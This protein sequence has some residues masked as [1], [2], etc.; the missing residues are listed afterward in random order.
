MMMESPMQILP[1]RDHNF[2]NA[3]GLL[4]PK[5]K[6]KGIG[7]GNWSREENKLFEDALAH[8][9]K[10]T[11]DRWEKVAATIPGKTVG[12][13]MTHYRD[14]EADVRQIEEAGLMPFS[15]G[16]SGS[17]SLI[18]DWENNHGFRG[19]KQP[20]CVG[21]KRS[22]EK[23]SEHERTKGVPWTEQEHKLFLMGLDKYGKGD[24]RSISRH[25]VKTRTPTQVASHAQKY[26][27]RLNSGGKDKRRSSIH[28]ITSANLLDSKSSSPS[29]SSI[30][31]TQSNSVAAPATS[32]HVALAVEAKQHGRIAN[33]FNSSAIGSKF[34]QPPVGVTPYEIE[35]R[36]QNTFHGHIRGYE[37]QP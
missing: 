36:A 10:D 8:F 21:A 5:G 30:L 17:S 27:I 11:D 33:G 3:S 12:D 25:F 26:F 34:M 18:L 37:C 1:S 13:V 14:L 19:L 32:V 16:G 28:D 20:F 23:S 35:L 31:T 4:G 2:S 15:G 29:H 24:W 7:G 22:G 6:V 9:D